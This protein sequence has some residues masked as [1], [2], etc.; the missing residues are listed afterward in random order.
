[1]QVLMRARA[2]GV[3]TV[4]A[5]TMA[6]HNRATTVPGIT[7]DMVT[8]TAAQAMAGAG[9]GF[10]I[11]LKGMASSTGASRM[12]VLKVEGNTMNTYAE[13]DF[14]LT[15]DGKSLLVRPASKTYVDVA[16]MA[17]SAMSSMPPQLLAQLSLTDVTGTMEKIAGTETVDG[18]ATNHQR[19]VIGYKMNVM[20]QA[21][22]VTLTMDYWFAN[23]GVKFMDPMSGARSTAIPTGPFAE[24]TKKQVELMKQMSMDG[25]LMKS[26]IVTSMA[27][28]G[29]VNTTTITTEMKNVK[30]G[31]VDATKF[32]MPDGY[33]KAAK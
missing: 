15:I 20:G 29:Q 17:T 3:F 13:G 27:M 16:E 12:D 24:L 33:T 6:A 2:L 25:V 32:A 9:G 14:F 18:R 5:A 10:T 31:D 8:S 7:F 22:P 30:D 19:A 26:T 1:M 4:V 23:L 28:M 11:T 21:I